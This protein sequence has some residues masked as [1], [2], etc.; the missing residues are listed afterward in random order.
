M[1]CIP[2]LTGVIKLKNKMD[3]KSAEKQL[4]HADSFLTTLTRILKKH[5]LI[6]LLILFG[7]FIYWALTDDE[8]QQEDPFE[9]VPYM[10]EPY[11]IDQYYEYDEYAGDSILIEVWSDG[12]EQEVWDE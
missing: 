10:D 5:W 9:D 11:V 1:A 4:K 7:W 3:I 6:L 8:I 2:D 12:T